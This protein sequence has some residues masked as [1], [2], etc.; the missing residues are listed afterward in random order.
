MSDLLN[1]IRLVRILLA[2]LGSCTI[3]NP[4]CESEEEHNLK[5]AKVCELNIWL[6]RKGIFL[7]G[8]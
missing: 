1:K 6:R 5:L 2:E 4:C 7:E 8:V 3:E